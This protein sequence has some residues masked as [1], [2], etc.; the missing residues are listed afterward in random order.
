M[1]V[2]EGVVE[3]EENGAEAVED[4]AI[5]RIIEDGVAAV[6]VVEVTCVILGDTVLVAHPGIHVVAAAVAVVGTLLEEAEDYPSQRLLLLHPRF[7]LLLQ[8]VLEVKGKCSLNVNSIF[9]QHRCVKS[10]WNFTMR[11]ICFSPWMKFLVRP[12]LAKSSFKLM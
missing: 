3:E 11:K 4:M 5:V 12:M 1:V 8:A 10:L 9:L 2:V 7:C 6:V